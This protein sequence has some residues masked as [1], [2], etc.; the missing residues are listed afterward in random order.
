[1]VQTSP[2]VSRARWVPIGFLFAGGMINYMDRAA[3][4]VAAPFV[5]RD[6]RLDAAQLGIIFSAF[7]AG[8]TLFTFIG[9]YAADVLGPKRVFTLAM[10]LW[11]AFCAL[12]A[13]A[14]G[15]TSL[16]VLRIIFGFGEGPFGAAA[17]KMVGNWFPRRQVATAIGLANAGTPIGGALA[18][19]VAGW[20]AVRYGW[21][22]SFVALAGLGFLWT[23]FWFLAVDDRPQTHK[24]MSD[25]ERVE[26]EGNDSSIAGRESKLPLSYYLRQP[27]V[28]ATGLSFFG[29]AY[30]LYFFLSW[31]PMYLTMA[32]HLN[33]RD[34]GFVNAIP[35]ML[36][37]LGLTLSGLV[38]DLL[39]RISGDVLRA[40]KLVLVV[41][42]ILA[43]ICVGLAGLFS[44]LAWAVAF[45]AAA[46]FF[47]Y[48]TGA[49]YWAIIQ[50]TVPREHMGA[51]SGFVHLIANCAGIIGP[52]VTGFIVQATG[53]FT[54]AFLLA[55]GVALL[56]ALLVTIF[57]KP[58]AEP[59]GSYVHST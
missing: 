42:L 12:T 16:L 52:A 39:S 17:N 25:A 11:S 48:L 8:Y 21:R 54:S 27:A 15:F 4:S 47:V 56:G 7:F 9:G 28:I 2:M 32:Q 41:C 46:I 18:G 1:V 19:P 33:I 51:T 6:L 26:T 57:V 34:M 13:A 10:T 31:F 5:M 3:L 20:L 24:Q 40:R 36:G 29:Y 22:T 49:T 58:I 38:C 37:A 59:L 44:G 43:A 53:V 35:W 14:A 45:M 30:V 55:G 50:E 23:F